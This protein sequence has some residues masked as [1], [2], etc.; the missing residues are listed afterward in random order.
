MD[1][2]FPEDGAFGGRLQ[3]G[4]AKEKGQLKK[5]GS[6]MWQCPYKF[7][8]WHVSILDKD[9]EFHSS[10]FQDDFKKDMVPAGG[11]HE[12]K[13]YDGCPKHLTNR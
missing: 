12:I 3:C 13:Y 2:G 1:K 7:D 5:D 9:G 10:C 8:F 11:S 4:L 6:V